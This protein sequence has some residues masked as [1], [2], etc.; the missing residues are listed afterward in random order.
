MASASAGEVSGRGGQGCVFVFFFRCRW[1]L[2]FDFLAGLIYPS[3]FTI[4]KTSKGR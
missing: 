4:K 1:F 3:T 2:F